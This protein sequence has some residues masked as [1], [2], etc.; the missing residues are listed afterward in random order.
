MTDAS[1]PRKPFD[2]QLAQT[3]HG[4]EKPS[5]HQPDADLE[6]MCRQEAYELTEADIERLRGGELLCFPVFSEYSVYVRL[7]KGEQ[8]AD[9]APDTEKDALI[10]RLTRERDA[11][12][13]GYIMKI[14]YK[15]YDKTLGEWLW[16]MVGGVPSGF[17]LTRE[18]AVAAV[19]RAVGIEP[20]Q[21]E[22]PTT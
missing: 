14:K 16:R 2:D 13:A 12:I 21:P 19:L 6:R 17:E 18:A 4:S 5:W 20:E 22:E 1:D 3:S 7:A 11:L 10:A 8:V 9:T 15:Q